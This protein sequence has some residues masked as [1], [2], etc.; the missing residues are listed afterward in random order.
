MTTAEDNAWRRSVL[1]RWLAAALAL[2]TITLFARSLPYEFVAY[3]DDV[4]VYENPVVKRG[5]TVEGV[6]YAFA[7]HPPSYH[8]I[9]YL[10]HMTDVSLFGL[11][12]AGHRAHS[13]AAHAASAALLLL[14]LHRLTG[15][16]W[17]SAFVAA[18]F[19]A[20]PLRVESVVWIAERKDVT[21]MLLML[22]TLHAYVS[23]ARA[24]VRR[25][26]PWYAATLAL[27]AMSLLAKPMAV[28]LPGVMILLDYW[29]LRRF[30][31]PQAGSAGEGDLAAAQA[32]PAPLA[33]IIAEKIPFVLLA[34]AAS[35]LTV[36]C[37]R[38]ANA[39]ATIERTSVAM[40]VSIAAIGYAMYW[41]KFVWPIDL[42]VLYPLRPEIPWGKALA[43]LAFVV[44]V[45][46]LAIHQRR[47]RPI[48]IVGWLWYLGTLLPVIG[49]VQI[50]SLAMADRYTYLPMIGPVAALVWLANEA[51]GRWSARRSLRAAAAV[52][53]L[54]FFAAVTLWQMPY[55]RNSE[56][57]FR[58]ALAVGG[59][60][61]VMCF[62]LGLVLY[63]QD[64]FAEA[65]PYF[66]KSA[67]LDATKLKTWLMLARTFWRV[68]RLDD[69]MLASRQAQAMAPM[70][71]DTWQSV[72]TSH[73]LRNELPDAINALRQARTLSGG[74]PGVSSQLSI[75][76]NRMGMRHAVE[77]R[78]KEAAAL[79]AE[80]IA[81]NPAN[82]DAA[83]NLAKARAV[84]MQQ[85]GK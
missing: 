44:V 20:H 14:L 84:M 48:V 71:A 50:G 18:L 68:N 77:G 16:V 73:L 13:I 3:D 22:L 34:V 37:Q 56:T 24:G 28:T 29:P 47:R 27:F 54:A 53:V 36:L 65:A 2:V 8:P 72:G 4:F 64:R 70:S 74:E 59:D 25:R 5:L 43:S 21:C 46:A 76:L 83:A 1:A 57:L 31:K 85:N 79:F 39:I 78:T 12:P 66:E 6:R 35:W 67:A 81:V 26:V 51:A 41:A 58:R 11:S 42:A 30:A 23:Y 33:R 32:A 80:A 63:R 61:P 19:A 40:R 10:S 38:E 15:S 17:R 69:A 45:T 82:A 52:I 9:A 7:I 55:W 75:A 49:L 60:N 62:N